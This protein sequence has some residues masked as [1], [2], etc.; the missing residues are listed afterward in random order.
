M[1]TQE[2]QNISDVQRAKK[3]KEIQ[4]IGQMVKETLAE[5]STPEIRYKINQTEL[6]KY[7]FFDKDEIDEAISVNKYKME[8]DYR[9]EKWLYGN[10]LP[11]SKRIHK[12]LDIVLLDSFE[13]ELQYIIFEEKD[14]ISDSR[15]NT[16]NKFLSGK[17]KAGATISTENY[18]AFLELF[19]NK[20]DKE[21][22][23][24]M[25][26]QNTEK[27][28]LKHKIAIYIVH[29]LKNKVKEKRPRD[30][31]V[32]KDYYIR[33]ERFEQEFEDCLIDKNLIFV[34]GQ[35]NSGKTTIIFNYSREHAIPVVYCD[36]VSS[37]N[38]IL[39]Q[40]EFEEDEYL[41]GEL[42]R[43][44]WWNQLK[45]LEEK[46]EVRIRLLEKPVIFMIGSF[47]GNKN[48]LDA[49]YEFAWKTGIRIT[50]EE[51]QIPIQELAENKGFA[52]MEIE[53]LTSD[54]LIDLF[55]TMQKKYNLECDREHF[56]DD[57]LYKILELVY[58]TP[59]L[60]IL[61]AE[62][63]WYIRK[64]ESREGAYK[65]LVD[66][67]LLL[68]EKKDKNGF[69]EIKSIIDQHQLN[70]LGHIKK[71]FGMLLGNTG[72][73]VLYVL[74]LLSGLEIEKRLVV[75]W[76]GIDDEKLEKLEETGWCILSEDTMKIGI[77]RLI[78]K[79]LRKKWM[80]SDARQLVVFINNLTGIVEKKIFDPVD[81]G[82]MGEVILRVHNRLLEQIQNMGVSI[83]KYMDDICIFHLVCIKYFLDYANTTDLEKLVKGCFDHDML[84]QY[85]SCGAYVSLI[86]RQRFYMDQNNMWKVDVIQD[87]L[88]L[89]HNEDVIKNEMAYY[90]AADF[91]EMLINKEVIGWA[92]NYMLGKG[93]GRLGNEVFGCY[94]IVAH[95][96]LQL[97]NVREKRIRNRIEFLGR[98]I[99]HIACIQNSS[100]DDVVQMEQYFF[101]M[102]NQCEERD[103]RTIEEEILYR[104]HLL[105]W[106]VQKYSYAMQCMMPQC[107][108]DSMRSSISD[109][110]QEIYDKRDGIEEIPVLLAEVFYTALALAGAVLQ[111]KFR[112]WKKDFSHISLC[113]QEI[114][115]RLDGI[116]E[117]FEICMNG[118]EME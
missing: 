64:K 102:L 9:I 81:A 40:M 117:K 23:I 34:S 10:N 115:K 83:K 104:S 79:A 71:L 42:W 91:F 87:L 82:M 30:I 7:L 59:Q 32:K 51:I 43:Y 45:T 77:S 112:I 70:I 69:V 56:M 26:F 33:R 49:I 28:W 13:E 84:Y 92:L 68:L 27:M 18:D 58:S 94:T 74:S 113:N 98:M 14:D 46:M 111:V 93:Y 90:A 5:I 105:I 4:K 67:Q 44:C 53:P 20:L 39:G 73:C 38:E 25:G 63:Y 66:V 110:L 62:N 101:S 1:I 16:E 116:M 52:F 107:Q 2:K 108:I 75:Q 95:Y 89:F 80:I 22:K 65:F 118:L 37:L 97:G 99:Y 55:W 60:V 8:N 21:L 29:S 36:R 78:E 35:P 76:F 41:K 106:Y 109:R 12:M 24:S 86:E 3:V 19:E 11:N 114:Q 85:K 72:K 54:Q 31:T 88:D 17:E 100:F 47:T 50:I 61:I 15:E 48:D 6:V 103:I 57:I 96:L